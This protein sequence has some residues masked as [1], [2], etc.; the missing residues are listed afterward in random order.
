MKL[1]LVS[2]VILRNFEMSLSFF[3][4]FLYQSFYII[5]LLKHN[6]FLHNCL[7]FE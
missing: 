2:S 1:F 6:Y 7:A 3:F 5:E 4:F